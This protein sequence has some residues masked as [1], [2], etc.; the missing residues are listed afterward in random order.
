MA[1]FVHVLFADALLNA[2]AF[3]AI[4]VVVYPFWLIFQEEHLRHEGE[5][6]RKEREQRD[7]ANPRKR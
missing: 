2:M 3:L 1:A 6:E 5:R 7:Q 4:G